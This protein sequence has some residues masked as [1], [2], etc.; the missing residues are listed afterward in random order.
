MPDVSPGDR[1]VY[2]DEDGERRQAIVFSTYEPGADG[3]D[4]VDVVYNEATG[5]G[6]FERTSPPRYD[7]Q[8]RVDTSVKEAHENRQ[9]QTFV[10]GGWGEAHA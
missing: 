1:V 7:E 4:M 2:F 9:P 3:R 5:D 6:S 10:P 8:L